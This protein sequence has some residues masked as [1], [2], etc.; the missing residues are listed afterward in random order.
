MEQSP[1]N[2]P[3]S[4]DES[5]GNGRLFY[6]RKNTVTWLEKAIPE[7]AQGDKLS[8][9]IILHG[10]HH[11]GKTALLNQIDIGILGDN[12]FPIYIDLQEIAFDSNNTFLW[13]IANTAYRK[14]KRKNIDIPKLRQTDFVANANDAFRDKFLFPATKAINNAHNVSYAT[15]QK[16][17]ILFDNLHLLLQSS[18]KGGVSSVTTYTLHR[19]CYENNLAACLFAFEDSTAHQAS[20]ESVF[21]DARMWK[22]GTLPKEETI[23]LIRQP[24]NYI[25]VQD[26]AHYIYDLTQGQPY[27]TQKICANL[28][29]R[30]QKYNLQQITVADVAAVVRAHTD[31]R[32]FTEANQNPPIYQISANRDGGQTIRSTYRL[33]KSQKR[34]L[35]FAM[36]ALL[37]LTAVFTL[38][39]LTSR[40]NTQQTALAAENTPT[41]IVIIIEQTI[42]STQIQTVIPTI[43]PT[44]SVEA[45]ATPKQQATETAINTPTATPKPSESPSRISRTQD[46]M[47]MIL[48][49]AGT[50]LM[51]SDATQFRAGSD[52]MPAHEVTLDPFYIDKYEVNVEQ[53]AR[54][55]NRI[56]TY[57]NACN[58]TDCAWPQ[59]IAGFSYLAEEDVGDGTLQ[60]FAVTGYSN[61]PINQVSWDGA[62]LYCQSV[63]ARLPSE[64]EWEYAARGTDGR[65]YP[66][67]NV[68]DRSKAI[69]NNEEFEALQPVDALPEGASPFG[70]FGM[71][72][73]MWEW[74]SDWYNDLYYQNSP[75][76]NPQGP[77]TGLNKVTRGGAWPANN[78][79]DRVRSANRNSFAPDFISSTIGF[80]CA[81]TP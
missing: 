74:T 25:L 50:F 72:G 4:V 28:Y 54:F 49:P 32:T 43:L 9:P 53:Y 14:L 75:T 6:G 39:P 36:V 8:T 41:P 15:E 13:D 29:K 23:Q 31:I 64:A 48:I 61:Y 58:N 66:W 40:N 77:E 63:G 52:E 26:V 10:P 67:G 46:G 22:L 34:G 2:N 11:I 37:V 33:N 80:R 65:T 59:H 38:S 70:V 76:E 1:S 27:Y 55:L 5:G 45:T 47:P 16:I 42:I 71:A 60:Y 30:Q 35:L 3:Y 68:S 7:T 24:V 20:Q 44:E 51:G 78:E 73:S 79:A 12:Y 19:I 56:G 18:I 17:L 69:Y 81:R 62:D 21:E 57:D